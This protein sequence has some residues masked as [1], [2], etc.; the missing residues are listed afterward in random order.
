MLLGSATVGR[1]QLADAATLVDAWVL[2]MAGSLALW[3][4]LFSDVA[5]SS[6]GERG[7]WTKSILCTI[8]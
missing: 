1:S 2:V 5:L 6:S 8:M 7:S 4:A 3:V